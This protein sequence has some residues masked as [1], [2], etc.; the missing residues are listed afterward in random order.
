MRIGTTR[1]LVLWLSFYGRKGQSRGVFFYAVK[2]SDP[3]PISPAD[4]VWT[5]LIS[6]NKITESLLI[7]HYPPQ[8]RGVGVIRRRQSY[9][10]PWPDTRIITTD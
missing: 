10:S 5:V 9:P 2:S 3:R 8:T 6:D 1:V 7:S 4:R